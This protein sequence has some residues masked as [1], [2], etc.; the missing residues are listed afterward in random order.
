LGHDSGSSH[1][2]R[3]IKGSKDA[4]DDLV[5]KK[6]LNQKINLIKEVHWIGAQGQSKWVKN[7]KTCFLCDVTKRKPHTQTNNFLIETRRLAESVNGLNSSLAIAIVELWP[8]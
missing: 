3:S 8:N 5:S 4:D 1:A 2:R 7:S 6:S